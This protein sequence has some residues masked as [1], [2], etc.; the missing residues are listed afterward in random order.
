MINRKGFTL[1]EIL[2]VLVMI[3]ILT[4]VALPQYKRVVDKS[5]VSEAQSV[6]RSIYDSSE[7]L[8]G[9][10]GYRSYE[11]L[12]ADKGAENESNYSFPRLDMFGGGAGGS[13]ALAPGCCIGTK[14]ENGAC[15]SND[16]TLLTCRRFAYK[17]S[18]NGYAAAKVLSGKYAGTYILLDRRANQGLNFLKLSCQPAASDTAA[19][20]CDVYGLDVN[21]A[22]VNF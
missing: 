6:L 4:S 10:F 18:Q 15:V 3:G 1:S 21:N 12:R 11:Q 7:R 19:L 14:D 2:V 20:A 8:A 22:G 16:N 17:I 5:R 9:E 13:N